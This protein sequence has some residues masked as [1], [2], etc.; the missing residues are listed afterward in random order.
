MELKKYTRVNTSEDYINMTPDVYRLVSMAH[1]GQ[2]DKG[3]QPYIQHLVRVSQAQPNLRLQL[4]ALA[5]DIIE[6]T[7]TSREE[8][9]DVGFDF[10]DIEV[11]RTLTK[12]K[13]ESYDDYIDRVSKN[14]DAISIKMADLKDN[15]NITRLKDLVPE[16]IIPSLIKYA[17]AYRKLQSIIG[18]S[19]V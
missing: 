18:N 11:I 9:Y 7:E 17:Q 14:I 5:H 10:I 15:M 8:L 3:E 13:D 19:V 1:R 16:K 2:L 6:D 12:N 4:I